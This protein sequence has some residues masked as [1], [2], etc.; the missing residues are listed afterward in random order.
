M[1]LNEGT[2]LFLG[3]FENYE[4]K[5]RGLLIPKSQNNF[6]ANCNRIWNRLEQ[7]KDAVPV[8]T[9]FCN[10]RGDLSAVVVDGIPREFTAEAVE[11]IHNFLDAVQVKD[12]E[13][14]VA[15]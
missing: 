14:E 10:S 1:K 5:S 6:E 4:E 3:S 2:D 8:F 15:P 12:G 9:V 7:H 11:H 13:E